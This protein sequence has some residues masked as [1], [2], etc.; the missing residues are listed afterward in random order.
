MSERS[1]IQLCYPFE[2]KRLLKWNSPVIIQPKLDGERCRAIITQEKI[3]LLSSS[4]H[5]IVS[6][7]HINE[8]LFHFATINNIDSI[9]LDGEL[10][11]HGMDFNEI[12]SLVSPTVNINSNHWKI[13]Y[14]I[15]D[16]VSAEF[17]STRLISLQQLFQEYDGTTLVLV[18]HNIAH[19]L[20]EV[21]LQYNDFINQEFEGIIVRHCYA[22]YLRKRS[23]YV[24]KFKPKKSDTYPI[25]GYNQEMSITGE[26]KNSLGSLVCQGDDGTAFS[27]GSGLTRE[28]RISLWCEKEKLIGNLCQVSYQHISSV[29]KVPRFPVFLEVIWMSQ[30]LTNKY[31]GL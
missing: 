3:T 25:I 1:G 18:P 29:G 15:F 2:E 23:L 21:M 7:P 13:Q 10:Y 12:Q 28:Q 4:Q 16:I 9:E 31:I 30:P 5:E 27:V 26:L 24:M 19:S 20:E 6:V 22:P 11:S 8:E 14:H 17:Q